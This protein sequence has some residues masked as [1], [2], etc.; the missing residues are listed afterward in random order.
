[1]SVV[2][3][4]GLVRAAAVLSAVASM[5]VIGCEDKAVEC[6]QAV[7]ADTSV[8]TATDTA[9]TAADYNAEDSGTTE[10][11]LTA[12][13]QRF[14][15]YDYQ[16]PSVMVER[17]E[18]YIKDFTGRR[19]RKI[20]MFMERRETYFP[21]IHRIF[22]EKKIP[23]DLAYVALL[24]SGLDPNAISSAGAVGLWQF[25][26]KTALSYGLEISDKRDER[27]NPE[28]A[29]YA[30]AAYL[31]DLIALFGSRS[32]IMLSMSAY[33]AGEKRVMDALKLIEDPIRERDFW[34]L[35]KNNWLAEET[36]EYVPQI[37]ALMILSE[38]SA[39]YGFTEYGSLYN[40]E[41]VKE[42]CPV[43]YLP[44]EA[45]WDTSDSLIAWSW[46]K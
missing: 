8:T 13:L 45:E 38:Y 44:S 12:I 26:P 24:E 23:L 28:K 11:R 36:N 19:K 27:T 31:K 18:Y 16:V 10:G 29:T 17:V 41:T 39:E 30:A 43:D 15:E 2:N 46:L 35:Y 33:N 40:S 37:L 21:M 34:H 25:I 14:G 6:E 5:L 1:M 22:T 32:S 9:A 4:Y 20:A 7:T 42:V 3:R